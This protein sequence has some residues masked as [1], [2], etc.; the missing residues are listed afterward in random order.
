[1][2]TLV[3]HRSDCHT[4]AASMRSNFEAFADD[5]T[6]RSRRSSSLAAASR[7]SSSASAAAD[8]VAVNRVTIIARDRFHQ[9]NNQLSASATHA[10]AE[11]P[12]SMP[13]NGNEIMKFDEQRMH[14]HLSQICLSLHSFS[15]AV[16]PTPRTAAHPKPSA[17][18]ASSSSAASPS[19]SFAAEFLFDRSKELRFAL[20]AES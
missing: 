3:L 18:S 12:P 14:R 10:R 8:Q 20:L 16:Q 9:R 4:C 19:S 1:M 7:K 17:R 13:P 15:S 5:C 6:M 11:P 2:S